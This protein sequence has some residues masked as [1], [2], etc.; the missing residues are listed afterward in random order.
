M[1]GEMRT[2][3]VDNPHGPR[4]RAQED[5][6]RADK[7]A[8]AG[9]Q[10]AAAHQQADTA[11]PQE[12]SGQKRAVQAPSTGS[13]STEQ[14]NPD[15]FAGYE[16]RGK[17]GRHFLLRPVQGAV[18]NQKEEKTDDEA[19]PDLGPG[20]P[21]A[22]REAPNKKNRAGDQVAQARGVERRDCLNGVT[23]REVR[24]TPDKVNGEKGKNDRG[25]IQR[26][27]RGGNRPREVCNDGCGVRGHGF[28]EERRCMRGKPEESPH[29]CNALSLLCSLQ[30]DSRS[31]VMS[32]LD[33]KHY[34]ESAS[35]HL[36]RAWIRQGCSLG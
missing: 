15:R 32:Q 17:A 26:G 36:L 2:P 3:G 28:T 12:D 9:I 10:C 22:F 11:E 27:A 14:E 35:K 1:P 8:G 20:R 33:L 31:A 23:N 24:G 29:C 6:E 30:K 18:A 25:A 19:G 7:H 13:G 5:R 4:K 34:Y 21:Q 16:Q